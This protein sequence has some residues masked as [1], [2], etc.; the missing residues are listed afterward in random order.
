MVCSLLQ[1]LNLILWSGKAAIEGGGT[2]GFQV[3]LQPLVQ[4]RL[5]SIAAQA[6]ARKSQKPTQ[7]IPGP[8]A[9]LNPRELNLLLGS[10]WCES[11]T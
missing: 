1:L 9:T 10:F 7:A 2:Q 5:A 4:S 11:S 8:A 6:K 3:L